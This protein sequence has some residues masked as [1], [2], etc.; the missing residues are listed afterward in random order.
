ML[1]FLF[2]TQLHLSL[3]LV[4]QAT[5]Q[6]ACSNYVFTASG[7]ATS[8]LAAMKQLKERSDLC[9][10]T[11][12]V[13]QIEYKVHRLVLAAC[14]PYFN[15][16]FTN[17]HLESSLSRVEINGVEGGALGLLVDFAYTASLVICPETVQGIMAA[18]SHLQITDVVDAC[19]NFLKDQIDAENCL[20]IAAFAEML[21]CQHLQN[22][23]WQFA[24]ENFQEVCCT[25]E[26][27]STPVSI[28]KQLVK[29]ESL[30]VC[31]EEEVFECV[32]RWY[33]HDRERRSA[34]VCGI[35]Y[36]IKL[37]LIPYS[38]LNDRLVSDPILAS[39]DEYH[40]LLAHAQRLQS[41]GTELFTDTPEYSQ[42][43]PRKS[44]G[45][46]PFLYVVGGET[47]PG[48][49]TVCSVERYNPGKNSWSALAP[50]SI[51]RRGVGTALLNSLLYVVGGSS[52]VQALRQVM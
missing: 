39:Q 1:Y 40:V 29:S 17:Q 41:Q 9:D 36:H 37:P 14:S 19:C 28:L 52:G 24:L 44:I 22:I 18:A 48:R 30:N 38:L 51:C 16:M 21:S 32:L 3:F 5:G 25:E 8:L 27:L 4:D 49:S 34:S 45:Q 50:M 2:P 12:C 15:A 31:S 42:W 35:L 23:S 47:T 46:C 6:P 10:V 43:I 20:G 33:G 11:L 7:H 26:F 13:E